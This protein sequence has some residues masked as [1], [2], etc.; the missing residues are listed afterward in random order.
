MK[1]IVKVVSSGL[2]IILTSVSYLSAQDYPLPSTALLVINS[3]VN[4]EWGDSPRISLEKIRVVGDDTGNDEHYSYYLPE[5]IAVDGEG[6]IY[7]LDA[8]NNRVV[9]YDSGW[10]YVGEVGRKG[11]GPGD[12]NG[13]I[14]IDI[15][16]QGNL[17]ISETMNRRMQVFSSDLKSI[18]TIR[19]SQG[20]GMGRVVNRGGFVIGGSSLG[21]MAAAMMQGEETNAPDLLSVY[22]KSTEPEKSFGIFRDLGNPIQNLTGSK[23]FFTVDDQDNTYLSFTNQNRIEKY[24]TDGKLVLRIERELNFEEFFPTAE[25]QR[26]SAGGRSMMMMMKP[27]KPMNLVSQGIDVDNKGRIW[28]ITATRQFAEDEKAMVGNQFS[29]TGGAMDIKTSVIG[30]TE[31][32]EI[33]IFEIEIFGTDGILLGKIPLDQIVDNFRIFGDRLYIIDK[34]RGMQIHVFTIIER[35]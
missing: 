20:T 25:V 5:D 9:K 12:L 33:Y 6:N 10:N 17:Y 31:L 11:Q 22:D 3:S 26:S 35:N 28:V 18:R 23:F 1:F 30:N 13:P 4:G 29:M 24:D 14:S 15:D 27:E 7:V 32:R 16:N 2:F 8:G 21:G 34:V 19:L